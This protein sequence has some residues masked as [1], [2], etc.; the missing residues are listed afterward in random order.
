MKGKNRTKKIVLIW[1]IVLV[2]GVVI[3]IIPSTDVIEGRIDKYRIYDDLDNEPYLMSD[4][5]IKLDASEYYKMPKSV[6]DD[7]KKNSSDYT[8]Y[9]LD[10]TFQNVSWH[11]LHDLKAS[12]S[13]EHENVWCDSVLCEGPLDLNANQEYETSVYLIVKTADFEDRDID[14]LIKSLGITI[15]SYN[16]IGGLESSSTI[17]FTSK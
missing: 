9:M 17:Y 2:T 3:W 5:F 13:K 11:T 16:G 10:M 4:A 15:S 8:M 1:L 6:I 7:I 14:R 12:L